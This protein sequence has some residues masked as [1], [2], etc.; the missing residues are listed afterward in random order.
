MKKS[1]LAF[2]A[3][4]GALSLGFAS[5]NQLDDNEISRNNLSGNLHYTIPVGR[6]LT[7]EETSILIGD[8]PVK[9][10]A[11]NI[12]WEPSDQTT[13][14][15]SPLG[16]MGLKAG[17]TVI[18]G[19][20]KNGFHRKIE[21]VISVNIYEPVGSGIAFNYPTYNL[22]ITEKNP[23]PA[24]ILAAYL[25][26]QYDW[27]MD[28]ITDSRWANDNSVCYKGSWENPN[29]SCATLEQSGACGK[30]TAVKEGEVDITV[31]YGTFSQNCHVII[32]KQ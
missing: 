31:Q 16:L 15:C 19:T 25:V 12:A 7:W 10:I 20:F 4:I 23:H 3:V 2:I 6:L 22:V 11:G 29:P 14:D 18:S 21:N 9:N 28:L 8:T 13:V 30:I 1:M 24:I 17:S 27:T 26:D 32:T 5:C